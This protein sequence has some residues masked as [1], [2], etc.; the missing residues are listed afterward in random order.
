MTQT[1]ALTE[2]KL[3]EKLVVLRNEF[4]TTNTEAIILHKKA[5]EISRNINTSIPTINA[6]YVDDFDTV[7]HSISAALGENTRNRVRPKDASISRLS[8]NEICELVTKKV[9]G[10]LWDVLFNRLGLYKSM[11]AKQKS[12][13]RSDCDNNP[14]SFTL[15]VI[16]ETLLNLV[17]NQE[18]IMI[19]G[20]YDTFSSLKSTY[21]SNDVCMFGKKVVID[22]AFVE[23]GDSF[24]LATH[25]KLQS[26]IEVVWRWILVNKFEMTESGVNA[27]QIW[28]DVS[29]Q[30]E[31]SEQDYDLIKSIKSFSI[32]FR[33]FKNKNVHVLFPDSMIAMLN[34]QLAKKNYIAN[35]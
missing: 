1:T 29:K 24:K 4:I 8:D 19:D 18:E 31:D 22:N 7:F 34:S 10:R 9:D 2:Q 14:M 13:F 35:K 23:Y 3:I 30:L 16:T 12:E 5:I 20:L 33:F 25:N 27:N 11:S 17:A 21:V 28:D 32:E 15:D 6:G 26:L